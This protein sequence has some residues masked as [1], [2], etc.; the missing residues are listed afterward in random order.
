VLPRLTGIL[1]TGQ[2]FRTV[3]D[4]PGRSVDDLQAGEVEALLSETDVGRAMIELCRR[5][6]RVELRGPDGRRIEVTSLSFSDI[7]EIRKVGTAIGAGA[8]ATGGPSASCATLHRV[9]NVSERR[10]RGCRTQRGASVA[11]G[12]P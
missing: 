1:T 11:G 9:G 4:S 7:D 6:S 10:R 8:H 3:V 12:S 2:A 5:V